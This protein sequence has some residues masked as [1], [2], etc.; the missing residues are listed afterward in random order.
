MHLSGRCGTISKQIG[1]RKGDFMS[2]SVKRL[3]LSIPACLLALAG[4]VLQYGLQPSMAYAFWMVVCA[5]VVLAASMLKCDRRVDI[6]AIALGILLATFMVVGREIHRFETVERL[7]DQLEM[8]KGLVRLLGLTVLCSSVLRIVYHFSIRRTAGKESFTP[9]FWLIW[10]MI[11]ACWLPYFIVFHP[12]CIS[13]DSFMELGIILGQLPL[14]NHHPIIHQWTIAPFVLLG[15]AAGS[16]EFGIAM[17]TLFQMVAMSAIFAYTLWELGRRGTALWLRIVLFAWY[18]L[19]TVNAFYSITMWKD[20]L[21]GG[22]SLLTVIQ[23]MQLCEYHKEEKPTVRSWLLLGGTLFL[24]CLYRNNG[25]YAF[26]FA[27]PF[28]ILFNRRWWKPLAAVSLAVF[29]AVNAYHTLIFDVMNAKKSESGESLSVPLQ[30]IA[31]TVRYEHRSITD[32][33]MA[34]LEEIFPS[35]EE[36]RWAYVPYISDPVKNLFKSDVFNSNPLRYAEVWLKLGISHPLVYLDAFLNQ[37]YGY[38]YPDTLYWT[39]YHKISDNELGLSIP[40]NSATIALSSLHEQLQLNKVVGYLYRPGSYVWLVLIVCG[41]LL[42]KSQARH[43]TPVLFLLGIWLTTLLSPV[44]AE[45]R[46][47]YSI[48]VSAPYLLGVAQS[49]KPKA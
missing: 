28:F 19:H 36:V 48:T 6:V 15:Q 30:Q 44:F 40:Q 37:C 3:A 26:L 46:Y 35:V 1:M 11:F 8:P 45:Y 43:L 32:E 42:C 18:A 38:W 25:Y 21:F 14:S 5:A 31:R 34:I 4:C 29:V 22:L 23:L 9:P 24:F 20:V 10:M 49:I 33:E 41:L 12:G 7:V 39:V 2:R 16:L 13:P 27:I 47:V 17:Y